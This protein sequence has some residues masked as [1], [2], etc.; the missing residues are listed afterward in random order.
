M[1]K[2][3]LNQTFFKSGLGV[4]HLNPMGPICQANGRMD[5][6]IGLIR[7]TDQTDRTE[8]RTFGNLRP[9]LNGVFLKNYPDDDFLNRMSQ[10]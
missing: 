7:R 2:T 6:W 9:L 4:T 10:I 3:Y 8:R 1:T 5:R